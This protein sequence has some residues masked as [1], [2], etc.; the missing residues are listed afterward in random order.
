MCSHT[1]IIWNREIKWFIPTE[2]NTTNTLVFWLHVSVSQNHLQAN[3]K[4]TEVHSVCTYITGSHSV[5]IKS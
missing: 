4:Y 3:V 5:Y 1:I 2:H